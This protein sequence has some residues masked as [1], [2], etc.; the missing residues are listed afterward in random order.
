TAVLA[1]AARARAA[2]RGRQVPGVRA[3]VTGVRWTDAE[4]E[5]WTPADVVVSTADLH[6]TE[7]ALLP[8]EL[9]SHSQ[10]WWDRQVPGPSAVLVLLGVRGGLPQLEHH[11]LL[12]TRDWQEGFDR[13]FPPRGRGGAGPAPD[14]T[15]GRDGTVPDGT[16]VPDPVS[17]Y[18]CRPS[19]TDPDVAPPGSENL[20]VLV[21]VPPDPE[22]GRGGVGGAGDPWVEGVADAAIAQI[23]RWAGVPDLADRVVV[24]RTIGPADFADDLGTW[25]GTAL[26]PAH[27]LAQSAMF[28]AGN[29]SRAVE[30]LLHA[31]GSVIPGI[32]LPMCLISA[33]LVVKRL[34]GDTST[35]PLPEPLPE[36][37]RRGAPRGASVAGR[38]DDAGDRADDAVGTVAS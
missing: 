31:G 11:T 1:A 14:G 25:R 6:H 32:G 3:R 4:G 36:P 28:R 8:P 16:T 34:R 38:A 27:T 9:R 35:G 24:R 22:L 20:F 37:L 5:H 17:L 19:A 7:T 21:P 29:A 26:G 15:T 33:E 2:A 12:F 18:V 23:A 30:G 10:R 13:I